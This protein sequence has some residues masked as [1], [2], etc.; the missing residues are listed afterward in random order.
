[1]N[2]SLTPLDTLSRMLHTFKCTAY[3]I[4]DWSFKNLLDLKLIELPVNQKSNLKIA[5][6]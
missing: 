6:I 3:E 2:V 1:M 5:Q 4:A